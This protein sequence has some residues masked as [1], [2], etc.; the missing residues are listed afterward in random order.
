MDTVERP[1]CPP[2]R[3]E[4]CVDQLVAARSCWTAIMMLQQQMPEQ[5]GTRLAAGRK[6]NAKPGWL[7][8]DSSRRLSASATTA[9]NSSSYEEGK[10][11]RGVE[12]VCE[13]GDTA[14]LAH[15]WPRATLPA[16]CSPGAGNAR[17]HTHTHAHTRTHTHTHTHA[18]THTHTHTGR[19]QQRAG[20]R[21]PTRVV[22]PEGLHVPAC[23]LARAAEGVAL[24]RTA[25][26][27]AFTLSLLPSL[28]R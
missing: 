24:F 14:H 4:S 15:T 16:P 13:A 19:V 28:P 23:Q 7:M 25:A 17:T 20:P 9:T 3:L 6:P 8:Q 11:R 18:R 26:R 5:Q 21:L 12:D 1:R 2:G 10:V 22:L 27:Y